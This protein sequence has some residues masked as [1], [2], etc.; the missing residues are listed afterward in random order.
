[1]LPYIMERLLKN[2]EGSGILVTQ[3]KISLQITDLATQLLKIEDQYEYL[4]EFI[5][6]MESAK[7]IIKEVVQ[8][9]QELYC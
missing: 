1:M 9:I 5:E 3:A 2:L 8:A 4:V 6:M 7:Y